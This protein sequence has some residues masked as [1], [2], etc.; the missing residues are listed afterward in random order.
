MQSEQRQQVVIINQPAPVEPE[1]AARRE[2][3]QPL[4]RYVYCFSC[5]ERIAENA[6]NC[7]KCG[8]HLRDED[9]R[10]PAISERD[11]LTTLLL[12]IFTGVLGVHR[13]YT[14]H[15]GTG[16]LQLLTMGGFGIWVLIDLVTIATG[17]FRDSDGLL[18]PKK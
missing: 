16:V 2:P 5:G 15:I 4:A 9:N 13:F 8:A 7:P 6:R 18:I 3:E 1:Q 14:G 11:W 10:G 17:K 12:C